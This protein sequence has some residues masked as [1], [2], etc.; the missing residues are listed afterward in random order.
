[1]L[2]CCKQTRNAVFITLD[3]ESNAHMATWWS[4]E[5]SL[6]PDLPPCHPEHSTLI[7]RSKWA[8]MAPSIITVFQLVAKGKAIRESTF[9]LNMVLAEKLYH[10]VHQVVEPSHMVSSWSKES[11]SYSCLYETFI[12][13]E[14]GRSDIGEQSIVSHITLDSGRFSFNSS[15]AMD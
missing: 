6:S 5:P 11:T 10:H 13:I 8:L 4:Q 9:F 2:H 1:M 7:S 14:K 12:I 15:S 3:G